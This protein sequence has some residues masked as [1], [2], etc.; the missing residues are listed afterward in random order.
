MIKQTATV[1]HPAMSACP[2]LA[3]PEGFRGLTPPP[4]ENWLSLI[5]FAHEYCFYSLK[6]FYYVSTPL[7][8]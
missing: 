7:I 5:V 8:M 3:H 1:V 2:A 4:L 6:Q